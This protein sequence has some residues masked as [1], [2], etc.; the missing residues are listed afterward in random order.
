METNDIIGFAILGV[1][2]AASYWFYRRYKKRRARWI[3]HHYRH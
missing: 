3:A 1:L 2:L